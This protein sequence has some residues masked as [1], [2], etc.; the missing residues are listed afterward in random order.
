MTAE[1]VARSRLDQ[2]AVPVG[3]Q[4]ARPVGGEG[5]PVLP[6]LALGGYPDDHE[7]DATVA[8]PAG[9]HRHVSLDG[10]GPRPYAFREAVQYSDLVFEISNA[11]GT[12]G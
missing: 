3:D 4:L 10:R 5:D 1:P 6:G 9:L 12:W 7:F 11:T 8:A 2:D